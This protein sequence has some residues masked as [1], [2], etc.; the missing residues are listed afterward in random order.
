MHTE[1]SMNELIDAISTYDLPPFP[2]VLAH[3]AEQPSMS[4]VQIGAYIGNSKHDPLFDFLQ[5]VA[6]TKHKI[7][8][9]EPIREYFDLLCRNYRNISGI[10]FENVAIAETEG[11]RD[12]YRLD[13]SIDPIKHGHGTWLT[14]LSSL[15]EERMGRLYDKCEVDPGHKA[16]FLEHRVIEKVACITLH[17]LLAKHQIQQ[18]DLLQIDAEGYDYEIL[19]TLDFD[20]L[21]PS[22]I[23]YERVLLQKDEPAC[24]EMLEAQGYLLIDWRQDT[25]CILRGENNE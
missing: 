18:L 2:T 25:L 19:K 10:E 9:V 12:M 1:D 17:Q 13:G 20:L 23:N 7:V 21:K 3:L 22:F 6:S 15:R 8:L 5:K 24:R 14:Q 16:F 4:I 11:E